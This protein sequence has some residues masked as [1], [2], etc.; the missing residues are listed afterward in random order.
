MSST[1]KSKV[2][3]VSKSKNILDISGDD[4]KIQRV[5]L[6]SYV[7]SYSSEYTNKLKFGKVFVMKIFNFQKMGDI[8]MIFH[9]I[10]GKLHKYPKLF[11]DM[12]ISSKNDILSITRGTDK[13]LGLFFC[14]IGM[15]KNPNGKS[16]NIYL[17]RKN[18]LWKEKC[19]KSMINISVLPK[20]YP[21]KEIDNLL[22]LYMCGRNISNKRNDVCLLLGCLSLSKINHMLFVSLKL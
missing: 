1:S 4:V 11:K 5:L 9:D 22:N 18:L 19:E 12:N 3:G 15:N 14:I 6:P 20:C 13:L 2:V 10:L 7:F 8:I 21:I 17:Y 16:T